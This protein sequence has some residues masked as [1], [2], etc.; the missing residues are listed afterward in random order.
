MPD[1]GDAA[2]IGRE[3]RF[4]GKSKAGPEIMK[5]RFRDVEERRKAAR[6]AVVDEEKPSAVRGP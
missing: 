3:D 1:E 6:V 4:H 5:P 2:A